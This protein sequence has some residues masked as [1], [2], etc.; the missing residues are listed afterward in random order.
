MIS[1][2]A[3]PQPPNASVTSGS[4]LLEALGICRLRVAAV[5]T[6]VAPL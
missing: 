5:L 6:G 2:A 1:R 4:S 3:F